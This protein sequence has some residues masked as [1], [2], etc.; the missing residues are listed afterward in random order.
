MLSDHYHLHQKRLMVAYVVM[1][2]W[3]D[4]VI[5]WSWNC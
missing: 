1:I 5:S 3:Y 2:F 4:D